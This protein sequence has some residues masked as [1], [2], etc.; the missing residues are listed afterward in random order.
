MHSQAAHQVDGVFFGADRWRVGV[1][2]IDGKL[3]DQAA[4]PTQG[5]VGLGSGA[6]DAD[7]DFLDDGAQQ[8]LAVAIRGAR[9]RPHELQVAAEGGEALPLLGAQGARA[10]LLASG[11]LG[12][13]RGELA[14]ALLP[15]LFQPACDQ[16]VL[17][18]D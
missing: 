9:R 4:A 5:Q 11:K 17:R 10:L 18:L 8:L 14:Q 16:A 2:Q 6:F 15:L 1:R 12:L 7:D 3:G 13:S